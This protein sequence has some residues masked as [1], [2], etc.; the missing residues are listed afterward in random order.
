MPQGGGGGWD[1]TNYWSADDPGNGVGN[2]PGAPMDAG[3]GSGNFQFVAPIYG[4]SGRG[5]NISLAAAY[6]SRLWNKAGSQI[7]YDNDRGWPAPGFNLGFGKLL[8]MGVYNGGMLVDAD[9][10]RHSYTGTI[11][12][13]N[14]G[15]TF[16]GHT[17]DGSFV[18]YNYQ[19]GTGGP[20]VWAQA[21]LA[22]GTVVQ[23]GA[24]STA[25]V[26]P[27]SI[28]DANGNYINITY[29]NNSGPRIQTITDTMGRVINFYYD[30][31]NLLTAITA[32]G[33][34]GASRV[35][36]RFHYHQL[37]LNYVN[38]FSGLTPS[39]RD[40]SPWVVD[41]IFYPA[42]NTGYWLN[43][44]NSSSDS[45]STY[46]ML[47][48]VK[49]ERGMGFYA[50]SLND[51]G[52][53]SEGSVTRTETYNYPLTP[54]SSLT[55]APTYTHATESWTRDGTNV[56]S[57]T[58]LYEVHE[59]DNPRKTIITLPNGTKS[60]QYSYNAAGQYNDGLVYH[61]VT[62]VTSENSA[63]QSSNSYWQQ[64]AYD[65]PR[66]TRVEKTDERNQ[67]TAA[68]FIYGTAYNQ[69]LMCSIMTMAARRC[70]ARPTRLIRTA[71]ITPIVTF[72]VCR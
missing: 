42:T 19:S 14:W 31:N 43:D 72:S 15:T 41:A 32:P 53:V 28:E 11:T 47:A 46:G 71:R 22:N 58:T 57:A 65:S 56:D 29:V 30:A 20:I 21:K 24:M 69:S 39:V 8:G 12:P 50:S 55:D 5:I 9:G 67:T 70:C 33:I 2:P 16:V 13:Y 66:P 34:S 1:S 59:N 26:Y 35:L 52:N 61:D 48:K 18:D 54:D 23:Y 44:T 10:T 7:S 4:A 60:K 51:M 25:A 49:E 68:A 3:A 36:V 45:Y 27:T 37:A 40:S 38:A 62:Y 64:G 6:N 63:L 17:T